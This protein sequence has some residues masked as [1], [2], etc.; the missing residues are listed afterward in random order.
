MLATASHESVE[1]MNEVFSTRVLSV[2]HVFGLQILQMS[3]TG[4]I[5][6]VIVELS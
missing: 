2:V 6:K 5:G 3:N 1:G 4:W